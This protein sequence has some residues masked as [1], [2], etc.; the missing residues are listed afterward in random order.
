MWAVLK[1][2]KIIVA[3]LLG[4]QKKEDSY[5]PKGKPLLDVN[6][7]DKDGKTALHLAIRPTSYGLF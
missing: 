4:Y 7:Q 1:N 2:S 6:K 3:S 5:L